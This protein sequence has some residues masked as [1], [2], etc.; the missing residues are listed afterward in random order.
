M[1]N[2][3][4]KNLEL[5]YGAADSPSSVP[6][7]ACRAAVEKTG[8]TN[9]WLTD[10]IGGLSPLAGRPVGPTRGHRFLTFSYMYIGVY[11]K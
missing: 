2:F 3:E 7:A 8:A 6:V 4:K 1:R 11:Y 9:R 5:L 10:W